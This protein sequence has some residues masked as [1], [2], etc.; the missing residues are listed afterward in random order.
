[1]MPRER[2]RG[3]TANWWVDAIRREVSVA[4]TGIL[5]VVCGLVCVACTTK[6]SEEPTTQEPDETAGT[7]LSE[8]DQEAGSPAVT[9]VPPEDWSGPLSGPTQTAPLPSPPEIPFIATERFGDCVHPGVEM[10]CGSE[11]CTIPAGCFIYGSPDDEPNRAKYDE[12]QVQVTL[13]HSFE[14]QK[15]EVTQEQWAQ[16]GFVPYGMAFSCSD[17]QCPANN[18]TW[19]EALRYANETSRLAGLDQ[20]FELTDCAVQTQSNGFGEVCTV[21]LLAPT[22]YDCQGYRLPTS[23]EWEYAARAGTTTAFYSGSIATFEHNDWC[24]WDP[25]LVRVAWYCGNIPEKRAQPVASLLSN[26]W[27]LFDMLGNVEEWVM[28]R[29]RGL[30]WPNPQIDP[31]AALDAEGSGTVRSCRGSGTHTMCRTALKL[32][33]SRDLHYAGFRLART[34]G[35]GTL[36]TLADV[37]AT[38]D[39]R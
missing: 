32:P 27:G 3:L 38:D 21:E 5:V 26:A 4:S 11:W 10:Q 9:S 31:G 39:A 30:A 36:P 33:M 2:S 22:I 35:V 20:C 14:I 16:A 18:V 34:L 37:S 19:Y 23:A 13:T 15:T 24:N 12:E 1:M 6:G 28:D 8:M 7:G 25:N 17:P 29:N